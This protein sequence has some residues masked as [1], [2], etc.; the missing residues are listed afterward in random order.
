MATVPVVSTPSVQP[1]AD[2]GLPYQNAA[3]ATPDA[4]GASIGQAQTGLAKE[5]AHR[6]DEIRAKREVEALA[7][8]LTYPTRFERDLLCDLA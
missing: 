1:S 5:V 4:F 8:K 3:G 2:S 7:L 6:R